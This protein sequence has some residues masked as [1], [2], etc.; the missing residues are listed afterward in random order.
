MRI[1]L[2]SSILTAAV[3]AVAA[4][5]A[6]PAMAESHQINIP[7]NFVASGTICPAGTYTVRQDDNA[8][9]VRL[10]G[11][12]QGFVWIMLPGNSA[13]ADHHVVLTFDVAG[14]KY[15]L[16]TVQ[17]G[18]MTTSRLDKKQKEGIPAAEQISIGE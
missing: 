9:T 6:Q 5:A 17:Y 11:H 15:L 14:Q 16:R 1:N 12:N 18:P 8:S 7:F 3:L 13:Q 10:T 4:L 2:Q